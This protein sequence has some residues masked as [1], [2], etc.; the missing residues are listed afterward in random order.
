M[1]QQ[2]ASIPVLGV[3][4]AGR[5]VERV[6]SRLPGVIAAYVNGATEIAEV[7]YDD[8]RVNVE[9]LCETVNRCGFRAGPPQVRSTLST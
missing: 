9:T 6:L 3:A 8:V 5:S 7:D 4:C 1:S 2:H